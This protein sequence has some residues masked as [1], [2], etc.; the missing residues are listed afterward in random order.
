MSGKYPKNGLRPPAHVRRGLS[1]IRNGTY[2]VLWLERASGR[3]DSGCG[4]ETGAKKKKYTIWGVINRLSFN[5]ETGGK[6][7]SDLSAR[8]IALI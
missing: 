6:Y 2:C 3:I 7:N 4:M 8:I 5:L 1:I